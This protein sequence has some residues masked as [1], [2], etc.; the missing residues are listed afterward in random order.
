[1]S[2]STWPLCRQKPKAPRAL[3]VQV[4]FEF[5]SFEF[6]GTSFG[7]SVYREPGPNN[8]DDIRKPKLEILN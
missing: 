6:C 1:M 8:S 5:S 3:R 2:L 4:E 7:F